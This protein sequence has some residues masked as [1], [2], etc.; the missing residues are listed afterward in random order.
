MITNLSQKALEMRL[1]LEAG[2]LEPKAVIEWADRA[3][4]C[5][6]NYDDSVANI[7]LATDSSQ[8]ELVELLGKF[9]EPEN[10]WTSLE[11]IFPMMHAKLIEQPSLT[12]ELI[13]FLWRFH[14]NHLESKTALPANL[15]FILDL[16][17]LLD[18]YVSENLPGTPILEE[19]TN[20]LMKN[21]RR[22]A[23]KE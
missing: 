21:L 4:A 18:P 23:I 19:A 8:S 16:M 6:S 15:E 20:I 22:F 5:S 17:C 10:V 11:G 7:S 12:L 9:P 2:L 13:H 1:A 3:L 14:F